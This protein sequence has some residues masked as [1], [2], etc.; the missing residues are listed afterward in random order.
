MTHVLTFT[1]GE[2]VKVRV[3]VAEPRFPHRPSGPARSRVAYAAAHVAADPLGDN[4]PGAPAAIDWDA[5]LEVRRYLWSWGLG[6]A[7]AMDTAQRGMGLDWPAVRELISRSAAEAAAVGGDLVVGVGTDHRPEQVTALAD[8]VALYTEQLGF[9][10]AAGVTPVLM[11]SRQ[12]ARLA[13]GPEDYAEVYGRLLSQVRRPVLLHWLGE[14]FDPALAGY[15]GSPDHAAALDTLLGVI[16][17]HAS[18]IS[19]VK[20]SLLEAEAELRLRAELPPGVRCFTGDDFNYLELILGDGRHYSHALLG[21]FSAIA[22]AA[23]TALHRLDDGDESGYQ[24]ALAATV[25]LSRQ[26]FAAPT[27]Y[28]K[29]DIAFLSWLNG[30][31]AGFTLI[32]GLHG[33]RSVPHLIETFRLASAAGVLADPELA[34]RRMGQFLDVAGV[35]R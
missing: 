24:A 13:R 2:G 4:A 6:V 28:Y 8:V 21:A 27:Q 14:V 16:R 1:G 11:A 20:V 9:A 5:T 29:T 32:G 12:L 34:V 3:E 17:E 15:W 30:H 25:P 7:D 18:A 22:P 31:Q 26:V 19:G 35:T 23:A 10:E 33:G